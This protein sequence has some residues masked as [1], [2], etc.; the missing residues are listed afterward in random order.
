MYQMDR[1]G[2]VGLLAL[3]ERSDGSDGSVVLLTTQTIHA[4]RNNETTTLTNYDKS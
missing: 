2:I 1:M 3:M 4:L